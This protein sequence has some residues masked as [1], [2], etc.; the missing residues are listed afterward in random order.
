MCGA[1]CLS[2]TTVL[3]QDQEEDVVAK[4][5][6]SPVSSNVAGVTP[7]SSSMTSAAATESDPS[8]TVTATTKM[9][10]IM[11]GYDSGYIEAWSCVLDQ[12]EEGEEHNDNKKV[13]VVSTATT[14]SSNSTTVASSS[15]A[16]TIAQLKLM[17]GTTT[18]ATMTTTSMI[19]PRPVTTTTRSTIKTPS[20]TFSSRTSSVGHIENNNSSSSSINNNNNKIK[21]KKNRRPKLQWR[22]TLDR[23]IRS[24]TLLPVIVKEQ[25]WDKKETKIGQESSASPPT[26]AL[27]A[28]LDDQ[29]WELIE[30]PQDAEVYKEDNKDTTIPAQQDGNVVKPLGLIEPEATAV[31]PRELF[32][33]EAITAAAIRLSVAGT[34]QPPN[35]SITE[36]IRT[37]PSSTATKPTKPTKLGDFL[38]VTLQPEVAAPVAGNIATQQQR[39]A[40][41]STSMV[42]VIDICSV[43]TAW[44]ATTF[45]KTSSS[46]TPKRGN[47]SSTSSPR[48]PVSDHDEDDQRV[49][50]NDDENSANHFL[51]IPLQQHWVLPDTGMG[52]VNASTLPSVAEVVPDGPPSRNGSTGQTLPRRSPVIPSPFSDSVCPLLP[53]SSWATSATTFS[54]AESIPS[55][56]VTLPDGTVALLSVNGVGT[57]GGKGGGIDDDNRGNEYVSW[58]ILKDEHQLLLSYPAIGCGCVYYQDQSHFVCCLRGGTCYVIPIQEKRYFNDHSSTKV[59][60]E[61]LDL[62]ATTKERTHDAGSSVPNITVFSYPLDVDSNA[63]A[64]PISSR[65][66]GWKHLDA[67]PPTSS[68][69]ES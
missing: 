65:I 3:Q 42:E 60:D 50:K 10:Q 37:A 51:A 35:G 6:A 55:C 12:A 62:E 43:A 68:W 59:N 20:S 46:S 23:R 66:C 18:T 25:Q 57:S 24:M 17:T 1:T 30:T 61:G 22:G 44:N 54:S 13:P 45:R 33:S 11:V 8:P 38:V 39:I 14:S 29:E 21:I 69:S 5:D 19:S 64:T 16:S 58:G 4:D 28:P 56:G 63:E 7:A 52:L 31:I 36:T 67:P 2:V 27:L 49:G 34:D 15:A 48:A 40:S 41:S 32:P 9:L 53:N 26:K 47:Q